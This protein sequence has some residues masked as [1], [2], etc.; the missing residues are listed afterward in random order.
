MQPS[1]ENHASTVLQEAETRGIVQT[2]HWVQPTSC[3][4]SN[5]YLQQLL[6]SLRSELPG[7]AQADDTAQQLAP[8]YT[9][10]PTMMP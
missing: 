10:N 7:A 2:T 5:C 6:N 3:R 9:N 1:H 4:V 8:Q